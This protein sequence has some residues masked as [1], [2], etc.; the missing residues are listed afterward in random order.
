MPNPEDRERTNSIATWM[1][2][3]VVLAIIIITI[4]TITAIMA[5]PP[6]G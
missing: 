5:G 3:V 1:V 2:I 6:S 4:L